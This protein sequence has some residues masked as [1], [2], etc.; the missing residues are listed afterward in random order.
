MLGIA[1][2]ERDHLA[3]F[4]ACTKWGFARGHGD[5]WRRRIL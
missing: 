4:P 3:G 1:Q 2:A 5:C